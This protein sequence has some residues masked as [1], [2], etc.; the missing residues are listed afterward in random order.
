MEPDVRATHLSQ[1]KEV[2]LGPLKEE[3]FL[4]WGLKDVEEQSYSL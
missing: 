4:H 1:Y 2:R 3:D